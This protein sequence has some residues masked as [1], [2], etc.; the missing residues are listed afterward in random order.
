MPSWVGGLDPELWSSIPREERSWSGED[1][2][3]HFCSLHDLAFLTPDVRGHR[4]L[5]PD[6]VLHDLLQ[7]L[8]RPSYSPGT[9]EKYRALLAN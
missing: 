6:T 2:I 4:T 5:H 1:D 3:L 9:L 7:Q 8:G